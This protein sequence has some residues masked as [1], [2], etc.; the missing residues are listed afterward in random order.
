MAQTITAPQWGQFL[1]GPTQKQTYADQTGTAAS[2]TPGNKFTFVIARI[3]QKTFT[4][5][6]GTALPRYVV[7]ASDDAFVTIFRIGSLSLERASNAHGMVF[8]AALTA[9]KTA[10]RIVVTLDGTDT[11]TYDADVVCI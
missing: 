2:F 1:T 6:T 5:G 4:A 7:Q 10:V 8:C 3:A 11:V 9:V